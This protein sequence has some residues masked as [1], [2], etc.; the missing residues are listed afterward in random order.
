MA[1]HDAIGES[2]QTPSLRAPSSEPSL[3]HRDVIGAQNRSP[4]RKRPRLDSGSGIA[5]S[6]SADQAISSLDE[7]VGDTGDNTMDVDSRFATP[8]TQHS[9]PNKPAGTPSKVTINIRDPFQKNVGSVTNGHH[10]TTGDHSS[11]NK[12]S[13]TNGHII[14][15][16]DASSSTSQRSASSPII[17]VADTQSDGAED[18]ADVRLMGGQNISEQIE[19]LY[20]DFPHSTD[21]GY[22]EAAEF[23]A[24]LATK[25]QFM[26]AASAQRL[27]KSRSRLW[28]LTG[29]RQVDA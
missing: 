29:H 4:S 8:E 18:V 25:G 6:M 5:R 3:T 10:D 15:K 24:D 21:G 26:P 2:E 22:I 9:S 28:R 23:I 27:I 1:S 19:A 20:F 11:D 14:K 17:E 13:G 12:T 16:D 7:A